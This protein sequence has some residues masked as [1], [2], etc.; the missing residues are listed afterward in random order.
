MSPRRQ[1]FSSTYVH[2]DCGE[3]PE[4]GPRVSRGATGSEP[5]ALSSVRLSWSRI[6]T[7]G[8]E[9]PRRPRPWISASPSAQIHALQFWTSRRVTSKICHK[10][11][12]SVQSLLSSRYPIASL[13]SLRILVKML[14]NWLPRFLPQISLPISESSI[15]SDLHPRFTE[16]KGTFARIESH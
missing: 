1:V 13:N 9:F 3:A 14:S 10:F 6:G 4:T 12:D 11:L 15:L 2:A 8:P 7:G 5:N 16:S